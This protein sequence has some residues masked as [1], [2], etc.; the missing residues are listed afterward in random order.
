[1]NKSTEITDRPL[2]E[3]L[4]Q[5]SVLLKSGLLPQH[6]STPEQVVTIWAKGREVGFKP[7]QSFASIAVIKGKPAIS[8]EGMLA[9]IYKHNPRA[10]LKY[11]ETSSKACV[12][13]ASRNG[14]SYSRF[15]FT[16]EDAKTAGLMG[17]NTWKN[18]PAAMLRA[19]CISSVA[20][21]VFPDAIMGISYTAEELG[22]DVDDETGN[23]AINQ[24]LISN[25]RNESDVAIKKDGAKPGETNVTKNDESTRPIISASAGNNTTIK[26]NMRASTNEG[27]KPNE[28]ETTKE[29]E[30]KGVLVE[31]EP[32]IVDADFKKE[33][34][35]QSPEA[36]E[37]RLNKAFL[38][39]STS[40]RKTWETYNFMLST[41]E[42]KTG[43]KMD[44]R[45]KLKLTEVSNGQ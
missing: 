23:I 41:W 17:N 21:A 9:L 3:Q 35:T 33:I 43:K 6:I 34:E 26:S 40:S 10:D 27:G 22:A 4:A 13:D 18:Y 44:E 25:E 31:S 12:I 7:M 39:G 28:K 8:A 24:Q 30:T 29:K 36:L 2:S 5:A 11:I 16:I 20:R 45:S 32:V 19:R 1:M 37:K 15:S 42:K 14:V 38:M